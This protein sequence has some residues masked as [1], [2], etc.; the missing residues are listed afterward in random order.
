MSECS[1]SQWLPWWG[2][3]RGSNWR[4]SHER[5]FGEP[6]AALVGALSVLKLEGYHE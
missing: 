3:C 6:M 4:K 1:G 5:M 2:L